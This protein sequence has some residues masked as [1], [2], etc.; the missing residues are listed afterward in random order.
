M[1]TTGDPQTCPKQMLN[2]PN[3][4]DRR[5][6]DS[7]KRKLTNEPETPVWDPETPTPAPSEVGKTVSAETGKQMHPDC[8]FVVAEHPMRAYIA[9][10]ERPVRD[11]PR[12]FARWTVCRREENVVRVI[13]RGSDNLWFMRP[14]DAARHAERCAV[15]SLRQNI[16]G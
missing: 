2:D 14:I 15:L 3:V 16:N 10:Y 11:V 4:A 5:L 6:S 13:A 12:W 8:Y 9:C 1:N 7:Q